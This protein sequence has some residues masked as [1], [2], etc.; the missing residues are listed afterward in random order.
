MTTAL[1]THTTDKSLCKSQINYTQVSFLELIK[2]L[3]VKWLKWELERKLERKN[4]KH[5]KD[6]LHNLLHLSFNIIF[7][8]FQ[9]RSP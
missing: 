7:S 4:S 1:H 9:D 3:E 6:Y 2:F 5:V 8:C